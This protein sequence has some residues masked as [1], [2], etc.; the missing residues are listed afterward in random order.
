MRFPWSSS[1]LRFATGTAFISWSLTDLFSSSALSV[2]FAKPWR[3][4]ICSAPCRG[5]E[6]PARAEGGAA[7]AADPS[8]RWQGCP[9][10]G[11]L[12][13]SPCR[14]V[15]ET[16]APLHLF[17]VE[18]VVSIPAFRAR[19]PVHPPGRPCG[20]SLSH[21]WPR[22][23]PPRTGRPS[24]Q[25]L[26]RIQHRVPLHNDDVPSSSLCPLSSLLMMYL[27]SCCELA[28][29]EHLELG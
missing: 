14:S 19:R 4:Q 9:A 5:A 25:A 18:E 16:P 22:C 12:S 23:V 20:C 2:C 6:L 10:A 29:S 3:V 24:R 15:S 11:P 21:S 7:V 17:Q 1:L 26:P 28:R 8:T 13:P 27:L